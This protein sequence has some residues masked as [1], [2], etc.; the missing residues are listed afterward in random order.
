MVFWLGVVG[1]WLG[2]WGVF[3]LGFCGLKLIINKKK[4]R[5]VGVKKKM[6]MKKEKMKSKKK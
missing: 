6:K 1:G 4:G 5:W 2:W 3:W